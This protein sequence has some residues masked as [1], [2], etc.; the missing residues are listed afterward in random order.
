MMTNDN[1]AMLQDV[2][3]FWGEIAP[4]EHLVQIYEDDQVYLDSLEGFIAGGLRAGDG[5][6]VIAT[7]AH[8]DA[9]DQRLLD[10]DIDIFAARERDQY[11]SLDAV[12]TLASFMVNGW[13]DE[14]IFE[15]V[16]SGLLDRA[17]KHGRVRAFGEMVAVM[18]EQG[19][20]GATVG[21]EHLWHRLCQKEG[22][23]LFCAY[24][25]SG[26]T[27]DARVSVKNICDAHSR[28]VPGMRN[29]RAPSGFTHGPQ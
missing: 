8:R 12:Q 1:D 5:V 3:I 27:D 20:H 19:L 25:K 22:F 14:I 23:S 11:I 9:L 29:P 17:R 6:I 24:P 10:R 28:V 7:Q 18:W 2:E 26:F 13:P 16:V 4:C 15:K 21:L